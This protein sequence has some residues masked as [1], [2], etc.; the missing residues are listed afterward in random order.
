VF[1]AANLPE[2]F[3][4]LMAVHYQALRD[5]V[6]KVYPGRVTLFRA[7][8]RPLFRSHGR[9]LGWRGLAAGGLEIID[10]PGNHETILKE[11]RVQFLAQALGNQLQIARARC[12]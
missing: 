9:D 6:P 10:V 7:Q 5:Y 11:P 12:Y 1:G 8:T 3:R 2:H 4:H